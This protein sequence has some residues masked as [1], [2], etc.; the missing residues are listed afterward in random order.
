MCSYFFHF[1]LSCFRA[2]VLS[3]FRG[4]RSILLYEIRNSRLNLL[5][6]M[7]SSTVLIVRNQ[8]IVSLIIKKL[9]HFLF[10]LS[11]LNAFCVLLQGVFNHENRLF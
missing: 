10:Q 9:Y 5:Y 6:K 4:F 7:E 1:V 3:C 8:D 11:L 2:F